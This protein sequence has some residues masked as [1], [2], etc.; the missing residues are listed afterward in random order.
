MKKKYKNTVSTF[1]IYV[2]QLKEEIKSAVSG[3]LVC[4][5]ILHCITNKTWYIEYL[6]YVRSCTGHC[7]PINFLVLRAVNMGIISP[8]L[9]WGR[10]LP[11]TMVCKNDCWMNKWMNTPY[12]VKQ[13]LAMH[14]YS[15]YHIKTLLVSGSLKTQVYICLTLKP[16]VF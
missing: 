12:C 1:D 13:R 11:G 2:S 10:A 3:I 5:F 8:I 15:I 16:H 7:K 6:L 9:E 14:L 4:C